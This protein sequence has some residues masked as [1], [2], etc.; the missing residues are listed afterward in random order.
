MAVFQMLNNA[1][2]GIKDLNQALIDQVSPQVDSG[3]TSHSERAFNLHVFE[4]S[5]G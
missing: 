2:A 5:K 1:Y 4:L 3:W